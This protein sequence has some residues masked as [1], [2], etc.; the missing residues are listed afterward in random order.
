MS[1]LHETQSRHPAHVHNSRTVRQPLPRTADSPYVTRARPTCISRGSLKLP[2]PTAMAAAACNNNNT[3]QHM[4]A[5][6]PQRLA[7]I[8][9]HTPPLAQ[10]QVDDRSQPA[11]SAT[12]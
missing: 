7:L 9:S 10:V 4:H 8:F 2:T 12:R 3:M 11:R 1:N 6:E 5:L